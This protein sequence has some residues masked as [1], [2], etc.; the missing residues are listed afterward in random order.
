[1]TDHFAS[2]S[3]V[4]E[5]LRVGCT[6]LPSAVDVARNSIGVGFIEPLTSQDAALVVT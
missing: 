5:V 6:S 4:I 2:C 3:S 1:M